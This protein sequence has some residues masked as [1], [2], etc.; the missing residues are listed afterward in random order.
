MIKKILFLIFLLALFVGCGGILLDFDKH[1]RGE[2]PF[3]PLQPEDPSKEP[4][5]SWVVMVYLD[6]A[7]NLE[8][9]GVADLQEM[10]QGSAG[11]P[12]SQLTILVLMDRIDGY[13]TADGDWKGVRFYKIQDG[14]P[15]MMTDAAH[16]I[17]G[18]IFDGTASSETN[19]GD[20]FVL[21]EFMKLCIT[22]YAAD[23]YLLDMWNHGG[24]WRD[25]PQVSDYSPKK[26]I[27][28]DDESPGH[29]TL[30]MNEV[31]QAFNQIIFTLSTKRNK[32]RLDVVYM[33][34]CLMQMAEVAYE[35]RGLT[36]YLV[37]SE[38]TV[39]GNGGDY[40]D[41]FTRFKNMATHNPYMF[42]YEL[43]SSF[44][45]Q[46]YSTAD[47]T[48]S[49][50]NLDKLDALISAINIFADNLRNQSGS[51]IKDLRGDTSHF[52]YPDQADLYH[53]AQLCNQNIPGAVGGAAE[54]MTAI[55]DMMVKEYHHGASKPNVHGLAIY[56]PPSPG[57][58]KTDYT[59]NPYNIDFISDT[60]WNDFIKWFK[61]Q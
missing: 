50:I 2:N 49:A 28:W 36:K 38:E 8:G 39:P 34:A 56:F 29:D 46:Y 52:A 9:A 17:G 55:E 11:I 54:V 44:R 47:T 48:Q 30:Y 31:Q 15:Q 58:V 27:C 6:A 13:S 7:N 25:N 24:G 21:L 57:E 32:S 10:V 37:A 53:F 4:D 26:A 40:N 60:R 12:P 19:M 61:N 35:L 5:G 3:D 45:N 20:P 1:Q 22:N 23:Y 42:S 33:D 18:K 51:Q 41:I 59:A 14:V 16:R 43:V